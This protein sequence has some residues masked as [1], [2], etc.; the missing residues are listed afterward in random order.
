MDKPRGTRHFLG[1]LVFISAGN[2][3]YTRSPENPM[4]KTAYFSI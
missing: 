1:K 3:L 4:E 2:S